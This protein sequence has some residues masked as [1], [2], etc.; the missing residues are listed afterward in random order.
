LHLESGAGEDGRV[1]YRLVGEKALDR[2]KRWQLLAAVLGVELSHFLGG[3]R[4]RRDIEALEEQLLRGL[5]TIDRMTMRDTIKGRI[6][7]VKTGRKD[8]RGRE[9]VIGALSNVL[10]AL[11]ERRALRLTYLSPASRRER[12]L[13]VH[14]LTLVMNRG[15][16]YVIVELIEPAEGL[17]SRILLAVD[18]MS[19]T[20]VDVELPARAYPS[21]F[22]AD[23]FLASAFEIIPGPVEHVVLEVSPAQLPYVREHFWHESACYVEQEGET[24]LHLDVA[25]GVDL[26]NWILGMA[27]RV[28]VREPA[29]LRQRIR[30][31]L[32]VAMAAYED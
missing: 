23:D 13:M 2:H 1:E 26:E 18:R 32:S 27:D 19:D 7:V 28:W 21:D 5:G 8:Y 14:P 22:R 30:E 9:D 15:A 16:L 3:K 12:R 25:L 6:Y 10:D 31:R 4:F 17:P 11:L 20:T 29:R 24:L